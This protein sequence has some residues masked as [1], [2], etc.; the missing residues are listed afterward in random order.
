MRCYRAV[1]TAPDAHFL[2]LACVG[3][4]DAAA[5]APAVNDVAGASAAPGVAE[6]VQGGWLVGDVTRVEGPR[7][8]TAEDEEAAQ[9]G[10]ADGARYWL[11][12]AL[13][14]AGPP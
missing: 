8:A 3:A 12:H 9:Y 10:L 7:V 6:A 1:T 4:F 14:V 13:P 2:A 11:V 5:S